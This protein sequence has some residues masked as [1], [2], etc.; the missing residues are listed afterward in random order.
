MADDIVYLGHDNV[1]QLLFTED[2]MAQDLTSVL[3]ITVTLAGVTIES[4]NG[5][6]DPITWNKAGMETG[7]VLL[8]LGDQS[9]LKP[10]VNAYDAVF[11]VYDGSHPDGIVWGSRKILIKTE[12]EVS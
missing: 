9:S 11:V 6:S 12:V 7:E 8:K 10:R 3:K 5:V 2:G 1:I 4:D